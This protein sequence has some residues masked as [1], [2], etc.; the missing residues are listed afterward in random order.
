[1]ADGDLLQGPGAR[2]RGTAGTCEEIP[3]VPCRSIC[4]TCIRFDSCC[5]EFC[6]KCKFCSG[7]P[8]VESAVERIARFL[9]P[10]RKDHTHPLDRFGVDSDRVM[11]ECAEVKAGKKIKFPVKNHIE[12]L[13][14]RMY[15]TG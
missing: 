7:V 4:R 12:N 2:K 11:F 5:N 13:P 9:Y 15:I 1:M 10:E 3:P 8:S 14:V 6:D